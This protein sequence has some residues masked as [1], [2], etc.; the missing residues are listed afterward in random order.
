ML[1]FLTSLFSRTP[2]PS[3]ADSIAYVESKAGWS[4]IR[5]ERKEKE[6]MIVSGLIRSER[7][8]WAVWIQED[9]SLYGEW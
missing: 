2:R 4:G 8:E 3:K 9:G 6:S 5:F 7:Y 1:H